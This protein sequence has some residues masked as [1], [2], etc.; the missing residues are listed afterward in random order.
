[1]SEENTEAPPES[2]VKN[3]IINGKPD[4]VGVLFEGYKGMVLARLDG[5]AII[6][7]DQYEELSNQMH[8]DAT[9]PCQR[10]GKVGGRVVSFRYNSIT[11]ARWVCP[12]CL[13]ESKL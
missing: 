3:C 6:P 8:F 2:Y 4:M 9:E 13:D 12:H 5:Y 11:T 1:M 10:C 7:R